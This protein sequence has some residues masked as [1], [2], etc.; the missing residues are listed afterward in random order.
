MSDPGKIATRALNAAKTGEGPSLEL[1]SPLSQLAGIG[2]KRAALLR[3]RGMV[4]VADLLL[5][6]PSR[7][8][9]WRKTA[10][11]AEVIPGSVVTIA[12]RLS[13][14]SERPMR[15]SRWR[16]LLNGWLQVPDGG[17]IRVVWFNAPPQLRQRFGAAAEAVIQGKVSRGTDGRIE[18]VHPEVYLPGQD[19]PVALQPSYRA[20]EYLGQR[21]ARAA[22]SS[23]LV[24]AA[25]LPAALPEPLRV[26]MNLPPLADAVRFLHQPPA[27]ADLDALQNGRTPAHRALAFD[28]LFAFEMALEIDRKR[29]RQRSGIAFDGGSRLADRFLAELPFEITSAQGRAIG[30]VRADM[31]RPEQMN[32]LLM[33]DVGSGKTVV[34]LWAVLN[35]IDHG[36][37]AAVMAPTELLAEQHHATF[38]KLCASFGLGAE[39]LSGNL[40]IAHRRRV[41]AWLRSGSPGVVFGTHALIQRSVEIPNLGLAV[42][43]E[44]HR[45]GVFDRIR[46]KAL[47]PK[48]DML[49]LSATPIPRSL[50]RVLLSNLDIT[51]LDERP[52]GRPPVITSLLAE[53]ELDRAWQSLRE[54]VARGYRAYCILPLIESDDQQ[55]LAVTTAAAELQK[56]A[57]AGLRVGVMHGRLNTAEKDHVMRAFRDGRLQVLVSTTVIEVGIDVPEA[58]VMVVVGAQRY[59]LAQLHQL[60]GRIGRGSAPGYCYL[61]TTGQVD[62]ATRHKLKVLVEKN[63]GAEIAQAD[64]DLRG[65]GDLFGARQAGPLPLRFAHLIPDFD[66]IVCI[67]DLAAEWLRKDP[68]LASEHSRGIRRVLAGLV[69]SGHGTQNAFLGAG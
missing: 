6:F 20:G 53:N 31:A 61:V 46:L 10:T 33:G 37:Q 4:T 36:Y 39:L 26:R 51:T 44:Q 52:A 50:A 13:N 66:T 1:D 9:D 69:D 58:T 62:D 38:S 55:E 42:I 63:A 15:G 23:A 56:G 5:A 40:P 28:E 3:Q 19:P 7:Y 21:L 45:F 29:A 54:Q 30:E 12:G 27:D 59:G 17:R 25:D 2:P 57:L 34:A 64:L 16:R 49:L 18:I 24:A 35:A 47:G 60:R 65:P 11:A 67:H 22:V 14:L 8:T 41:L 32:R 48:A 43:D 68:D